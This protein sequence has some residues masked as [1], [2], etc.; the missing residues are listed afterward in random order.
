MLQADTDCFIKIGTG[1][2]AVTADA[3]T[4][5]PLVAGEKFHL[6]ALTGQFIAV[7]RK[8]ADGF[9]YITPVA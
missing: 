6:Q 3:T 7:I 8:T 2:G 4:S 5:I 9:L 1:G